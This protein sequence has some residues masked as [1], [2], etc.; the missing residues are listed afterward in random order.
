MLV[1]RKETTMKGIWEALQNWYVDK[2]FTNKLFST[3]TSFTS[4]MNPTDTMEQHLNKLGAM[5]EE[6]DAIG[7]TIPPKVKVMILLMSL[8]EKY[9]FLVTSLESLESIDT[10]KFPWEVIVTRLL[11][12]E[13]MRKEKYGSSE[14][15]I[16][17]MHVLVQNGSKSKV[18]KDKSRNI[19]NYCKDVRHWA[20]ECKKKK[21]DSRKKENKIM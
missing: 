17:I 14:L 6:L 21:A 20:R 18:N 7:A 8:L 3:R 5:V 4:Q 16:E 1:V 19:C 15:L 12:D 11:N 9:K 13:L 2:G 10:N